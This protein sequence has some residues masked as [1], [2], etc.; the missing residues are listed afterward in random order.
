MLRRIFLLMSVM[1][2]S[3]FGEDEV[4]ETPLEKAIREIRQHKHVSVRVKAVKTLGE[5]KGEEAMAALL[6]ALRE[7]RSPKV[8]SNIVWVLSRREDDE[9]IAAVCRALGDTDSMVRRSAMYMLEHSEG[10]ATSFILK[11][12]EEN[13]DAVHGVAEM[14]V[15][16]KLSDKRVIPHLIEALSEGDKAIRARAAEGLG[17]L[18]ARRAV[19]PLRRAL[20]DDDGWVRSKAARALG[21]VGD[22][23]ATGSLIKALEDEESFVRSAAAESLGELADPKA[24]PSLIELLADHHGGA[25]VQAALA[26]GKTGVAAVAPVVDALDHEDPKM[27]QGAVRALGFLKFPRATKALIRAMDDEESAVGMA[28]A[29]ALSM[30]E[31]PAVVPALTR[32]LMDQDW[33]MQVRSRAAAALGVLG[34]EGE[35]V[36]AILEKALDDSAPTVQ[37]AARKALARLERA[38]ANRKAETPRR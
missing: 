30:H 19:G 13:G 17:I 29:S 11:E 21:W 36:E 6:E 1:A 9:A 35:S 28:A 26:L 14:V 12:L 20:D 37:R 38:N 16:R 33:D 23:R 15:G 7:D 31:D 18:K 32:V 10:D 2:A 25:W 4:G 27:R 8:R 24:I 22:R 34:A 3:G 5:I